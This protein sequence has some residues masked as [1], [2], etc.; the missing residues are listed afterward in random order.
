MNY[1]LPIKYSHELFFN[2]LLY[3]RGK[4]YFKIKIKVYSYKEKSKNNS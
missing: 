3:L 2:K 4:K 1:F